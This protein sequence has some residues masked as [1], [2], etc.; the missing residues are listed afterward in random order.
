MYQFERGAMGWQDAEWILMT[1]ADM[2][3]RGSKDEIL[4]SLDQFHSAMRAMVELLAD[5]D[6]EVFVAL[7]GE[8]TD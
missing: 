5:P 2:L 6:N 3:T 4:A 7:T 8:P 1:A